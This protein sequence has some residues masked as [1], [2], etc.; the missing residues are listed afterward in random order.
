MDKL[1][2]RVIY[3]K[4]KKYIRYIDINVRPEMTAFEF[5]LKITFRNK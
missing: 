3:S 4:P 5:N 1:Q 2:K